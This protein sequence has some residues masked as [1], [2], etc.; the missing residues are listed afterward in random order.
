MSSVS[1]SPIDNLT[2]TVRG[3]SSGKIFDLEWCDVRCLP[4]SSDAEVSRN[5]T[6]R[7]FTESA[8]NA[9]TLVRTLQRIMH[10][11][12]EK[13]TGRLGYQAAARLELQGSNDFCFHL[14]KRANRAVV[15]RIN[16]TF[17]A[18]GDFQ[19]S[20]EKDVPNM[21]GLLKHVGDQYCSPEQGYMMISPVVWSELPS[22]LWWHV[23]KNLTRTEGKAVSCT[24]KMVRSVVT[25][26]NFI[27]SPSKL[28][29]ALD[30]AQDAVRSDNSTHLP[31][32]IP[33]HGPDR[34]IKIGRSRRNDVVL[35]RD[36]EVS[37][38]HCKIWRDER[39]D[40]YIQDLASTNG[41]KLKKENQEERLRPHGEGAD[42][43]QYSEPKKLEL[44][45]KVILGLTTLCLKDGPAPPLQGEAS[46]RSSS[47]RSQ[48]EASP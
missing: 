20:S 45:D 24:C 39:G 2:V 33:P 7:A 16:V 6:P 40:V 14:Q 31:I 10:G 11:D 3:D 43:R 30:S 28:H 21:L 41:T 48:H 27:F 42:L 26:E 12:D 8:R 23:L 22:E 19:R 46:A 36:P 32:D 34:E 25:S 38:R 5:V 18:H 13:K 29:L 15:R 9:L 1:F 47:S 37:K 35:L 44:G 17:D 4:S